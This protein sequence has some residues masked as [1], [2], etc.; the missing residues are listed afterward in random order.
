MNE[1][2]FFLLGLVI[3]GLTGIMMICLLQLNRVADGKLFKLPVIKDEK[4]NN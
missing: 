2:L 1:L 3:G 4:K